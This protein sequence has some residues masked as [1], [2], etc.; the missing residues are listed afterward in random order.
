[1]DARMLELYDLWLEKA[2]DDPD[3]AG[4]LAD[5]SG[6]EAAITDR[7]YCEL[8]FGTAGLRGVIGA[9]ANRMNVYTVRRAT[10][11]L[12]DYLNAG[13]A[14]KAAAISYDSRHK[15]ALFAREAA[16][17]LAANGITVYLTDALYPTPVLSFAVRHY[18]CG[19]G[20]MITASHNPAAYNGYK[21]YGA[22][23]CQMTDQAAGAVTACIEKLNVFAD[24]RLI[25]FDRAVAGGQIRMV[26]E[27]L[28]E[29][30]LAAVMAT[31]I[32]PDICKNQPL[33][34]IYTPLNGTGNLPVRRVLAAAG[35]T[36]LT[37]VPEQEAPDG[38]FPTCPYPNPETRQV[39][40]KGLELAQ[41]IQPDL[42]L[43]TDPD[44]DRVGVAV[45]RTAAVPGDGGYELIGGNEAGAL[46]LW[47]ILSRRTEKNAKKTLPD[48]P[49]MVKTIVTT[50]L[51]R[52]IA[53]HFG[54]ETVEVL[55]GFKYI[56]EQILQLETAGEAERFVFGYE[57][58]YGYLAGS[59]VRDKDAVSA[60]LLICEMAAYYKSKGKSL[61]GVLEELYAKF[62][63]YRQS[64]VNKTFEGAE[65]MAAMDRLMTRLRTRLR[66]QMPAEI[67]GYR[68]T[69]YYDY[70]T[71][72]HT[73][74]ETGAKTA[75]TLPQSNVLRYILGGGQLIIRPSGT[76]PKIKA[77]VTAVGKNA[78]EAEELTVKLSAAAE[79]ILSE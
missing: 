2:V 20:I 8:T 36:D 49:V 62:G 65:G 26:G 78:A 55:T 12:A 18:R 21:C 5:I 52:R 38:D 51:A 14:A 17:V 10:Q 16:R 64:V 59:Y 40:E 42:L 25:D 68:I 60:C 73:D 74:L 15:S 69:G 53:A 57:E 24:I 13:T 19:A 27:E 77:Y 29:P 58:S 37:V 45:P 30:Y 1:M 43:A 39:F 50:E 72:E 63:Y 41:T 71:S 48:R 67:A 23:G 32:D 56:G 61:L 3:L 70:Q 44:A 22:D 7:F 6:D 11:G 66:E 28:L 75:L 54:C 76:E 9:G 46:M 34:V 79:G 31:Q 47:Y 4:E 33:S 35:V